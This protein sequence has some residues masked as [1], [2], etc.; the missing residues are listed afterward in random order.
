MWEL[1]DATHANLPG[2]NPLMYD[3][4]MY[5]RKDV[6]IE[7]LYQFAN[8]L[9]DPTIEV[10]RMRRVLPRVPGK[11]YSE[12]YIRRAHHVNIH[13]FTKGMRKFHANVG[14]MLIGGLKLPKDLG[15]IKV[16]QEHIDEVDL[17]INNLK[18]CYDIVVAENKALR[19]QFED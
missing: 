11:I 9:N 17:A 14:S 18:K 15:A 5:T 4:S 2:E 1:V 3:E 13:W 7:Y 6:I 12:S 19:D 10:P 16:K 8:T